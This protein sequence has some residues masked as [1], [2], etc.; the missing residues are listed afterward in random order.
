MKINCP[1]CGV[2]V[3]NKL[4]TLTVHILKAHE[5]NVE[6]CTWAKAEQAKLI[7]K[8]T[9]Q[10][11]VKSVVKKAIPKYQGKPVDRIPP[12]RQEELKL[13]EDKPMEKT[14]KRIPKYLLQQLNQEETMA[15]EQPL[16]NWAKTKIGFIAICTVAFLGG[17][18][19][20]FYWCWW[21]V[22]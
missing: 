13:Q 14:L 7:V 10:S 17:F 11:I 2:K 4:D 20:G 5:D 19:V 3:D 12:K 21:Q 18:G 8:P 1:W 16:I 9:K 15:S 22:A 6:L